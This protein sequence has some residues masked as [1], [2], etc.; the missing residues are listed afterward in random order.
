MLSSF[1]FENNSV[2]IGLNFLL[3]AKSTVISLNTIDNFV[4][5]VGLYSSK[6]L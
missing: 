4:F 6:F 2:T 1:T 5:F 3:A